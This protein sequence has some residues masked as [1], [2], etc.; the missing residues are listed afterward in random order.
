MKITLHEDLRHGDI[1]FERE[2]EYVWV[3]R[4]KIGTHLGRYYA[5]LIESPNQQSS[6]NKIGTYNGPGGYIFLTPKKSKYWKLTPVATFEEAALNEDGYA[7]M[8]HKERGI[9]CT[10]IA[11]RAF[12][13]NPR[14]VTWLRETEGEE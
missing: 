10:T 9:E 11:T 4:D 12:E 2:A 14:F 7:L 13:H 1:E 5:S 8:R 6:A 3:P